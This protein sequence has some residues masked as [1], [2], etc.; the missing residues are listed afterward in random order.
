MC[1]DDVCLFRGG[2]EQVGAVGVLPGGESRALGQREGLRLACAVGFDDDIGAVLHR[3]FRR[4][5]QDVPAV[6]LRPTAET[7][8]EAFRQ[9]AVVPDESQQQGERGVHVAA[10]LDACDV[11]FAFLLD[12]FH[13]TEHP[14]VRPV[15]RVQPCGGVSGAQHLVLR[16]RCGHLFY[17][18]LRN[19]DGRAVSRRAL[20][21]TDK[22]F[23]V[24]NP[25]HKTF[26]QPVGVFLLC[27][28]AGAVHKRVHV[29]IEVFLENLYQ[30]G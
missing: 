24:R 3:L 12:V 17:H 27:G 23:E 8:V 9:A 21:G 10:R 13:R 1:R 16:Q 14:V 2:I 22:G 5:V 30:Y 29:A 11:F 28:S 19:C 4:V 7:G 15:R 26:P 20:E 25:V 6:E 18:L